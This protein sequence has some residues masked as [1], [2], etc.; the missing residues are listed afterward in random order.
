M[1]T[2]LRWKGI[3]V[4]AAALV[5]LACLDRNYENP[6]IS[7]SGK[8][9]SEDWKRDLDGNG[10][11]DSVE[12][13]VPGCR[14]T[15][16]ECLAQAVIQ[17]QIVA[18]KQDFPTKDTSHV[19]SVIITP[20]A[21]AVTS[22][23]AEAIYIPM[24]VAKAVPSVSVLPRN[25]KNQ[26][27]TLV[28]LNDALVRVSGTDLVPVSPGI[29]KIVATSNDGGF[30]F[31][32]DAT[33]FLKDTNIYEQGVSAADMQLVVGDAPLAPTLLWAPV[34][35]TNRGYSLTSSDP[36]RVLVVADGGIP[37]CK[38]IAAGEATLTLKTQGKGL[39]VTFLVLVKPAPILTVPV[40]GIT[41]ADMILELGGADQT[42]KVGFAPLAA[43]HKSYS[44]VSDQP[45]IASVSGT[46]IHAVSGGKSRVTITSM[47]G[48]SSTFEVTVTV[49]VASLSAPDI[50]IKVGQKRLIEPV[51]QPAAASN[52]AF[53]LATSNSEIVSFQGVEITAV[54][55]GSA[56]ITITSADG[57]KTDSFL[58]TVTDKKGPGGI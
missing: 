20:P 45:G 32:F 24:G 12:F 23:Q 15:P 6:F 47:D 2:L 34:D 56:T 7:E 18:A 17:S 28:S 11:A 9:V 50:T 43:T 30:T 44:L 49:R 48:P 35:V 51:F 38:A 58:V 40:L 13:Y 37:A 31:E 3:V 52:V 54:K 21:L 25:A 55:K 27:Y 19:D 41:A 39:T 42:P 46:S 8:N 57:G 4:G 53:T 16:S 22:I 36:T 29:A 14:A 5:C 1:K 26:G 33:V 10:I